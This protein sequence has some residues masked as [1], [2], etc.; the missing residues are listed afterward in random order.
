MMEGLAANPRPDMELGAPFVGGRADGGGQLGSKA[1]RP[2]RGGSQARLSVLW[3]CSVP[4]ELGAALSP[5]RGLE[6]TATGTRLSRPRC[7]K[8]PENGICVLDKWAEGA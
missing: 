5:P 3:A 1:G 2:G 8:L 7:P 6:P 4:F